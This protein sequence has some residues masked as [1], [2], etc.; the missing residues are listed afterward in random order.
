MASLSTCHLGLWLGWQILL[1]LVKH[2]IRL[3][4]NNK[5]KLL[6]PPPPSPPPGSLW[7]GATSLH[8]FRPIDKSSPSIAVFGHYLPLSAVHVY[9]V[10]ISFKFSLLP[11]WCPMFSLSIS[12]HSFS[13]CVLRIAVCSPL[14]SFLV[15]S[16]FLSHLNSLHSLFSFHVIV[17]TQLFYVTA[18]LSVSASI[19]FHIIPSI[20]HDAAPV[21]D[22]LCSS[23][24]LMHAGP[25]PMMPLLFVTPSVPHCY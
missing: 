16:S 9:T 23:L 6:P 12:P 24:L 22:P 7:V 4:N 3:Y 15:V 20:P 21:C 11:L 25:S 18:C 5:I 14:P 8:L 17:R 19:P 13:V 1:N 10:V 2:Q